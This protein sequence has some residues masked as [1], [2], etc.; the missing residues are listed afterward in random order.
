MAETEVQSSTVDPLEDSEAIAE[1]VKA[2]RWQCDLCFEPFAR[3][4]TP[5]R[6]ADDRCCHSLCRR[7][8]LGSIRWGGRCPYDNT[9]IPAIVVCGAMGTG[10]YVYH[11]KLTE[12]RRSGGLPCTAADCPG[13]V[14][15]VDGP[16]PCPSNCGCCGARHCAR[17]ICGVPWSSGHRCWDLMEE[18]R[19]ELE[20]R[21]AGGHDFQ[22]TTRRR[23]MGA[24]RFRP[25][26]QCG[27]MVE[28]V[29]GCNMVYHDSCRTRW[30]FICRRV[31]T[32]QDFDCK[33]PSSQPPTPRGPPNAVPTG[34]SKRDVKKIISSSA[35]LSAGVVLLLIVIFTNIFS[36]VRFD[37]PRKGLPFFLGTGV[38]KP[39]TCDTSSCDPV[40]TPQPELLVGQ[41]MA[42]LEIGGSMLAVHGG[43]SPSIHHLDQIRLLDRFAEIPHDGPLADLM[44]SDPD[45]DKSGF[46]ISPRGA[47]YVFGQ[48]VAQKFLHVNQLSHIVRA[49][50]LCMAGYQVLFDDT[51]STVWSAPNY[52]Y[53]FGN[54]ASI[55][56]VSEEGSRFF[57]VFGPAPES[58]RQRP[59]AEGPASPAAP[60]APAAPPRRGAMPPMKS[61]VPCSAGREDRYFT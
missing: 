31:G 10:E 60:A 21:L 50:Q 58:E 22:A 6:L 20:R 44:W 32:C 61:N 3:F 28:H 8:L 46:V 47:G 42:T 27:A 34:T 56:E 11:E 23:L 26:P 45:P 53:R 49:H 43:L 9:P 48:D 37:L 59:G 1:Q 25:C 36:G 2:E 51:L 5:W 19:Q 15:S 18:E 30:C 29:G 39:D 12:A 38:S 16:R 54:T 57:N 55:L 24:P 17:R 52:C 33:A 7:C 40:T 14:P 4:E 41:T 13:V 35:I